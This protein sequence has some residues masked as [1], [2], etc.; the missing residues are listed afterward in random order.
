M[1][2]QKI[3]REK[4]GIIRRWEGRRRRRRRKRRGKARGRENRKEEGEGK[5]K[6]ARMAL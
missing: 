2:N 4:E 5:Y 1:G 3:R 6:G